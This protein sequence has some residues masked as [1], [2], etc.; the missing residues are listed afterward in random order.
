M[1]PLLGA[2]LYLREYNKL[3]N[4][5]EI[6]RRYFAMNAFDGVLIIIGVLNGKLYCWCA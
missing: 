4:I 1:R 6:A 3:A 2:I 5:S